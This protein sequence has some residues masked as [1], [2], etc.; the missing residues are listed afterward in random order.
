MK[1]TEQYSPCDYVMK[2]RDNQ[3]K[4]L[5]REMFETLLDDMNVQFLCE[6]VRE[7]R[8]D[9]ERYKTMLPAI[10]WQSRFDGK[11]RTDQNARP[12]GLFC[13][14]V[15]IHHEETFKDIVRGDG[16]EA[17]YE[18]ATAE[19]RTRACRWAAMQIEQDVSGCSPQD[20]LAILAIHISPSGT[21]VH[22]VACCNEFCNSIEENQARLAK[23]LGTSYDSV[24][25]DWARIFF[26]TPKKDWTYLD[27][28]TLF[29]ED[30]E[31]ENN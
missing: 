25:K 31:E 13:I 8:P 14:D 27:T 22:V 17:A 11:L 20:D 9:S 2:A 15:D 1:K 5:T 29:L 10:T 6:K 26:V 19:A 18:W 7:H 28:K 30:E 4:P 12:S 3:P 23:L 16:I 24:C 21:G